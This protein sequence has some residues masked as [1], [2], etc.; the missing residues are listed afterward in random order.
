[1]N[2]DV[3]YFGVD[4]PATAIA[5]RMPFV[6]QTDGKNKVVNIGIVSSQHGSHV[7][8]IIAGNQLFGGAMSG[9]APGAKIKSVRVC[10]FIAGC[11][12]HALVEGMIFVA[13]QGNVDV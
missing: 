11:T 5:E 12:A 13:K 8:G 9:A 10:L 1:V 4:N 6:V 7:A 2:F 3:N